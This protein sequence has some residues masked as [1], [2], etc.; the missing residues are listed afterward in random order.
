MWYRTGSVN[1]GVIGQAEKAIPGYDGMKLA[2]NRI[3]SNYK[4]KV[5]TALA[6]KPSSRTSPHECVTCDASLVELGRS[7]PA[8]CGAP[9]P[10]PRS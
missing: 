5:L 6:G 4:I 1:D 2:M 8:R 9:G 3:G 10:S 7:V